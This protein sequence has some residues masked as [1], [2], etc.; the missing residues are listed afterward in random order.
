MSL[1]LR[2]ALWYGGL[3]GLLI[4]LVC[5]YSYAVHGRAH[6]DETDAMLATSAEHVAAE[7]A[8]ARSRDDSA[9]VL[10]ASL[11]LGAAMRIYAA[12]GR[13]ILQSSAAHDAPPV[14]M[15]DARGGGRSR[16]PYPVLARFAPPLHE[17][18][19]P[20]GRFGLV[21]DG[22]RW[23]LHTLPLDEGQF[24][25]ATVPLRMIDASVRR[26]GLIMLTM[27]FVGGSITF[28]AGWLVARHALR[29]VSALTETAVGIARSREFSRRVNGADL[30]ARRDELGQ[31]ASTFNEMLAS[32]EQ[33][34]AAQQ[35][36]VADASHELRAP[37]TSIQGNLELLR[38]RKDMPEAERET[39]IAET[40]R[41]A[42]RLARL[43]SDLLALARADAGV[44]LRR[45]TLDL[46]RVFM[47]VLADARHLASGQRLEI[48]SLEPVVIHGDVDR[49]KQLLLILIDNAIK[50]TPAG[51][52]VSVTL[53]RE[54]GTAV[55]MVRDTGIGIAPHDLT[56]VFERF[57]RADPARS[58]DQGGTG[59]GLS[60]ARWI[61]EQHGGTVVL[62]SAIGQGTT[63]TVRL[64]IAG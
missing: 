22:T 25:V 14:S 34:Y 62:S 1:R 13:V 10:H 9:D 53:S 59:L 21:T 55:F 23:R 7:L 36:F 16:S 48:A 30:A 37:L 15:A 47:Q 54:G 26:F 31:L 29:P 43:V 44:P 28:L 38:D 20:R 35:R 17:R 6:Y 27:A 60:I 8:N 19:H 3:A 11:L 33:S 49:I 32:L 24:L 58:R 41:E 40:E 42:A 2:L 61:A 46:D 57:Y 12:D 50:Y 64:P 63:A 5:A 4:V 51:G 45:G 52:R 39:A 18:L 56:R